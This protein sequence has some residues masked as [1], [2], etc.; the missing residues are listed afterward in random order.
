MY[1]SVELVIILVQ[2]CINHTEI[3][4]GIFFFCDANHNYSREI[5]SENEFEDGKFPIILSRWSHGV[6]IRI[7]WESTC[8]MVLISATDNNFVSTK[9]S[10]YLSKLMTFRILS[11]VS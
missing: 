6:K 11:N 9:V 4:Y 7:D 1:V 10:E 2:D 5:H 3:I 8:H